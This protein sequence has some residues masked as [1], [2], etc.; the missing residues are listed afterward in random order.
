VERALLAHLRELAASFGDSRLVVLFGSVAKGAEA[1]WSDVDV[2]VAGVPFWR[3]LEIGARI[4]GAVGRS[5][6]VVEVESANDW[7]RFQIAR[8]GLL[9]AQSEASAWPRFQ[10]E[11][12]IRYFD[13]Q[14]ILSR[15]AEG[16]RQRLRG[17][18]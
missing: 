2:A 18:R 3:G 14:P 5:P 15:C 4:G 12:A 7:L 17:S 11:A 1:P 10:A 8:D 13:L 9:V 6:H 16:A